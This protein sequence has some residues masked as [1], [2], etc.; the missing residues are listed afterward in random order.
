MIG[1]R[2]SAS[3]AAFTKKL[4]MPRR[5]PFAFSNASPSDLR[6]SITAFM[7]TS[8]NEVSIA[9]EFFD[10]IRRSAMRV[11]MRVIGTRSS[12]RAPGGA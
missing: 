8:L 2:L 1:W 9:M 11:R 12:L 3:A 10:C 6:M 5:M 4:M 7:L